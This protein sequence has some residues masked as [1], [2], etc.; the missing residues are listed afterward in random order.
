MKKAIVYVNQFFGQVGGEEQA[1]IKPQL[2]EGQIGPAMQFQK[3]LVADV[4]HTII[5]GDNYM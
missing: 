4:T 1:G 2:H 5:C 3:E